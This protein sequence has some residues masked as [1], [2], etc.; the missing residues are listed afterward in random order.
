MKVVIEARA[1]SAKG[2][3]VKTYVRELVSHLLLMRGLEATVILDHIKARPEVAAGH[4]EVLPLWHEAFLPWWLS[5]SVGAR[6]SDLNPD[7]V[8]YTKAAVP[9][10]VHKPTVVTIYDVIPLLFPASQTPLRRFYWPAALLQAAQRSHH[11]LTISEASKADIVRYLHVPEDK[12]TVTQLAA[13]TQRYRPD[14]SAEE[15]MKVKT[16]LRLE[17][18]YILFV[19]TRDERKNVASL[20][21]AFSKVAKHIPHQLVIAGKP[22]L[23]S[24]NSLSVAASCTADIRQRIRFLDFVHYD[25]LPALYAGA[26]LFVWPSVYEGWG[27]PPQEAMASGV[28]V[29]VSNGG[30]LPEV[31]GQA[32]EIVPFSVPDLPAR[33][34]DE[35]FTEALADRMGSVLHDSR[36][37]AQMRIDGLVQARKFSWDDV[38]KKTFQVYERLTKRTV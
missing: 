8:H 1:L 29:I 11:I 15:K 20:I 34:H 37:M 22:A 24:D 27:F 4:E 7:V 14:I 19:A 10:V 26:D 21:R 38:A 5:R 16:R 33:T 32:G 35:I 13:D 17:G 25:D 18:P 23:K 3:G 2:G 28:P 31:V 9:R 12:V 6:I 30:P 36:R